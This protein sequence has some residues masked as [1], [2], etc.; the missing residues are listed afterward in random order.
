MRAPLPPWHDTF[1]EAALLGRQVILTTSGGHQHRGRAVAFQWDGIGRR[2][3]AI[4]SSAPPHGRL[5]GS[6][7]SGIDAATITSCA[8]EKIPAKTE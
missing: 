5:P 4:I 1:R 6:S 3:V 7:L 8:A 2:W